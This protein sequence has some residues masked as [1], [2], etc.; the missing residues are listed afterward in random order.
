MQL[1]S[2]DTLDHTVY[3]RLKEMIIN[4]KLQPGELIVQNQLSQCLGVSRTPLRKAL[5][6][7]EKEG[8]LAGTPKGWYIKEFTNEDMISVFRIRALM[9][10]LACRLAAPKMEYADIVY[11]KTLFEEGY[12]Q[13]RDR[14]AQAYY[15]A[16]VRFHKFIT[17]A[18]Q[19]AMLIQTIENNKIIMTSQV[20]GL[21]RDPEETI[22]EHMDIL[23][24][25]TKKDGEAAEMLMR[26]HIEKAIPLLESGEFSIYK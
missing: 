23:D 7:L 2:Y 26:K 11:L 9:E 25:L 16:D 17:D 20:Q 19:D 8:L 10:G 14:K 6:Q 5:A 18:T 1:Q 4:K 22:V 12:R 21:Y 24:A 3:T 15:Q 13:V